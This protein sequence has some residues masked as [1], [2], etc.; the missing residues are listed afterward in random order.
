MGSLEG[1]IKSSF[2]KGVIFSEKGFKELLNNKLKVDLS[3]EV[4]FKMGDLSINNIKLVLSV[5]PNAEIIIVNESYE[6]KKEDL[7]QIIEC[8]KFL[9][10]EYSKT[11][12]FN[13]SENI[14]GNKQTQIW[15]MDTVINANKKLETWAEEINS[16]R[17]N[18]KELS[19]F[20]KYLYA[21]SIV[22]QF[23]YKE[24]KN[25][26]EHPD[27]SRD[28]VSI[29][30]S[31][32]IVCVGFSKLLSQLCKMIGLNCQTQG[33]ACDGINVDHQNCCIE[34][35]DDKYNIHGIYYSDP[36]WDSKNET[37]KSTLQHS[38]IPFEELKKVMKE[39]VNPLTEGLK[40]IQ[41]QLNT[42]Q[43]T[44]LQ[45]EDIAER[46][47]LKEQTDE[48]ELEITTLRKKMGVEFAR[49][50]EYSLIEGIHD[51][52]SL[53][54]Y[55]RYYRYDLNS[56]FNINKSDHIFDKAPLDQKKIIS[57]MQKYSDDE[58][59][60][61]VKC[62]R[63]LQQ[64]GWNGY[65]FKNIETGIDTLKINFDIIGYIKN[66]SAITKDQ[67]LDAM[68]NVL[69]S[70]GLTAEKASDKAI[71][72]W[73]RS[74]EQIP[75][76][77][78]IES[79]GTPFIQ[80]IQQKENKING[81]VQ[82]EQQTTKLAIEELLKD[83]DVIREIISNNDN[84]NEKS[85]DMFLSGKLIGEVFRF[86]IIHQSEGVEKAEVIKYLQ[87]IKNIQLQSYSQSDKKAR[88]IFVESERSRIIAKSIADKLHIDYSS[89]MPSSQ[90]MAR[91]KEYFIRNYVENGY[92]FHSFPSARKESV[93]RDGF[94]RV[95][96]LWEHE[97]L[98]EIVDIFQEQ[99]VL[100]A[101]GGYGFYTEDITKG[102]SYVEHDPEKI[103]FHT[104]CSPEWFKILTSATHTI[105]NSSLE[106]SP[107]FLKNYDACKQNVIDLC[108]NAGISHEDKQKVAT[109]FKQSWSVLGQPELTTALIPRK[110]VGKANV[111][112][113]LE[114]LDVFS[115][116]SYALNDTAE[117]FLEHT[118]NVV[119]LSQIEGSDISVIEMPPA[120]TYLACD[121][122]KR[123]TREELY[124]PKN[125]I[126]AIYDGVVSSSGTMGL[127]Q[128][129]YN[130]V[131]NKMEDVFADNPKKLG[132]INKNWDVFDKSIKNSSLTEEKQEEVLSNF[133]NMEMN[134]QE[135]NAQQSIQ[136][137]TPNGNN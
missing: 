53:I 78:N 60:N 37:R 94:T 81:K 49:D 57:F 63:T 117:E 91:I 76:T 17:V 77:Q 62:F 47:S 104:L 114:S 48:D 6:F 119:D 107:F 56:L 127:T 23:Q 83:P 113:E 21:Y 46:F 111:S 90:N 41:N 43:I 18:G 86:S 110:K 52:G 121:S 73:Q 93:Q 10:Q 115:T 95:E 42:Q 82:Q 38:L 61:I 109:L 74:L 29:L 134:R 11:I 44:T 96:K 133:Q 108:N 72:I 69:I 105:S 132:E 103:F 32:K 4:R 137:Q 14:L 15:T 59:L 124:D 40:E 65:S 2:M 35:H 122:F 125:N 120:D 31:D 75:R 112:K 100:K 87:D 22:T 85:K 79:E 92:V 80:D 50:T 8:D 116:I 19:P 5:L 25:R 26:E 129:Q 45:L 1:M 89:G 24:E 99:G 9:K 136:P 123:E 84:P 30:N 102:K 51:F 13:A 55:K 135:L 39:P 68:T 67:Y 12:R 28:I 97:Q 106:T 66:P 70:K 58:I 36:C 64:C 131:F 101:L 54:G 126:K 88:T 16:A 98:K 3:K 33:C 130:N 7:S 128:E 27:I 20:E 118:G 71:D 34:L